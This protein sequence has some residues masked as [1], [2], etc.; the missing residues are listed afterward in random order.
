MSLLDQETISITKW[1][2][3][4]KTASSQSEELKSFMNSKGKIDLGDPRAL[5]AY[6]MAV[7]KI[8]GDLTFSI[9]PS[10]LV[11]TICLRHAYVSILCETLFNK[12]DKIIEVGTGASAILSLLAAKIH[13]LNVVAT[14]IDNISY[15]YAQTNIDENKLNGHITLVKS[16]GEILK[17]LIEKH[18][19]VR[20]LISYPPVYPD[21]DHEK[22]ADLTDTRGFQGSVSEMIGGGDDGFRFVE[23][24]LHEACQLSIEHITVLLIF[25]NHANKGIEIL[26]SYERI[27]KKITLQAGTRKRYLII[28][29][30]SKS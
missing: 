8:I 15:N 22:F 30:L 6:N 19:P 29:S 26:R 25:E 21:E 20:G 24:M 28:G 13:N 17:G 9:P 3:D 4:L 2:V 5:A 16:S 18:L 12:G 27:T 11:P 14:E 7:A 10:R 23:S 1:C